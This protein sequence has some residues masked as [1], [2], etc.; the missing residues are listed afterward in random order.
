LYKTFVLHAEIQLLFL[1]IFYSHNPPPIIAPF[2]DDG[3]AAQSPPPSLAA[4]TLVSA[5]I[6]TNSRRNLQSPAARKHT[7]P[8][9]ASLLATENNSERHEERA[10]L[11]PRDSGDSETSQVAGISSA[12]DSNILNRKRKRTGL[13]IH[14]EEHIVI[15]SACNSLKSATEKARPELLNRL[16]KILATPGNIDSIVAIFQVCIWVLY[17]EYFVKF[18]LSCIILNFLILFGYS[19]TTFLFCEL[20]L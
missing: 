19:F 12:E 15:R 1:Q 8:I 14:V 9:P 11:T 16:E 7:R 4:A 3:S 20:F 5:P 17:S 13:D 18:Y 10:G 6:S 2:K